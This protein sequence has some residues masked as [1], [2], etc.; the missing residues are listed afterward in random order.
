MYTTLHLHH[1]ASV[2][3]E[4]ARQFNTGDSAF[5]SRDLIIEDDAGNKV[6]VSLY[7]NNEAGLQIANFDAQQPAIAA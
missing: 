7:A 4:D 3:L 1:I 6:T 2:R 5:W